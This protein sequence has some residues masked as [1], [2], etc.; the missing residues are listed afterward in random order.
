MNLV[1]KRIM[2]IDLPQCDFKSCRHHFDGNCRSKELF[3]EC[4]YQQLRESSLKIEL[5]S[6][7]SGDWHAL[8]VNEALVAE[9]HEISV[10]KVVR[11]INHFVPLDYAES[12]ISQEEAEEGMPSFREFLF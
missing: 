9:G 3:R 2:R 11:G 12:E 1:E 7:T 5:V 8:Y 4:T 10:Y 6:S